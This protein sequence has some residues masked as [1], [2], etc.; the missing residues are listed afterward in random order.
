MESP[1]CTCTCILAVDAQ[2]MRTAPLF[3]FC[4]ERCLS[5]VVSC[6]S[7][8]LMRPLHPL[9]AR[10]VFLSSLGSAAQDG[11]PRPKQGSRDEVKEI[12][13]EVGV[14]REVPTMYTHTHT[15]EQICEHTHAV[16][17]SLSM[18]LS[19]MTTA[20]TVTTLSF[21]FAVAPC[22]SVDVHPS[23]VCLALCSSRFI[24]CTTH[25]TPPP[26][27]HTHSNANTPP[28]S[29]S[30]FGAACV[31][32]MP[33][34]CS[35]LFFIAVLGSVVCTRSRWAQCGRGRFCRAFFC[36]FLF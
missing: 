9:A 30:F 4:R 31:A 22:V 19:L 25:M 11:T 23:R 24:S 21:P 27:P 13:T 36:S 7:P 35:F 28:P 2:K 29:L 1:V 26:P 32:M 20:A 5:L 34:L 17:L 12:K 16:S 18:P 14:V 3:P 10:G 8:F 15:H 33:F 6:S